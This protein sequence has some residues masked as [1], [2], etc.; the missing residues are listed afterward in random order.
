[1]PRGR[2]RRFP[3]SLESESAEAGREEPTGV[4]PSWELVLFYPV[5][6]LIEGF[7]YGGFGTVFSR[8][9]VEEASDRL[10][11]WL[12]WV[13][14]ARIGVG[15]VGWSTPGVLTICDPDGVSE[16]RLS[17]HAE[18][19]SFPRLFALHRH[20]LPGHVVHWNGR[21]WQFDTPPKP[22]PGQRR[23]PQQSR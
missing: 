21:R 18:P 13:A 7:A 23:A 16:L 3:G 9:G 5:A 10:H 15:D 12:S 14:G 11:E 19:D 8:P 4:A 17:P 22:K 6:G 1:M 20:W 2:E